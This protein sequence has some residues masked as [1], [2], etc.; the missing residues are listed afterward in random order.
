M[1]EMKFH[2][3]KHMLKTT[4]V[5]LC[6]IL[7]VAGI[8]ALLVRPSETVVSAPTVAATTQNLIV[9]I[10][11]SGI[12]Q[13]VQ[14]I[15]L[16][17]KRE[18]HV[19]AVYVEEGDRVVQG[20]VIAQVSSREAQAQVNQYTATLAKAEAD[21]AGKRAGAHPDEVN[22]AAARIRT[23]QANVAQA[24][25]KLAQT[26]SDRERYQ[27][28]VVQGAI[29]QRQFGEYVTAEREAQA[30]LGAAQSRMEEQI[31]NLARL[32]SGARPQEIAQAEAGVAEARAQLQLYTA[33]LADTQIRAPFAGT[34]TRLFVQRGDFITPTTA[35]SANDGATS[36]S[37]AELSNGLEI[38]AR[39]PE[40]SI[41]RIRVGQSVELRTDAYPDQ[42]FQGQVR[43]IAPRA[44]REN[45]IT[46]FRVRIAV[47]TGFEQLK[48]GMNVRAGFLMQPIAHAL[49]VPLAAIV[50]RP[51]GETGVYVADEQAIAQFRPV[52]VGATVDDQIQI[53]QGIAKG[54]RV[55]LSPP[56]EPP[57]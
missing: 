17:P 51:T 7:G 38:E 6:G 52:T 42:V 35:A 57:K 20:Q 28:L 2:P 14:K 22:A 1:L 18:G 48:L 54:E 31:Q 50:T 29:S 43:L 3:K 24:R 8:A 13:P 45:N 56:E 41:A 49:V 5:V 23:E 30:A 21:L 16:S 12:V 27:S 34:I 53:L 36:S 46:A 47:K 25:A 26:Q 44:V 10:P 4:G 11:A 40:A 33:Q 37:I 15:N 39:V 32:R 19:V 9:K 55:L